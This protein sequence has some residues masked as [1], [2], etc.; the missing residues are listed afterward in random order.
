[1]GFWD[2][3]RSPDTVESLTAEVQGFLTTFS[4][5]HQKCADMRVIKEI[6]MD[7]EHEVNRQNLD[8]AKELYE[9]TVSSENARHASEHLVIE[10]HI[11]ALTR[12]IEI[13]S[14]ITSFFED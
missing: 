1:M 2:F 5:L 14:K 12:N 13:A 10:T 11:D 8:S 9:M 7:A 3:L 4:T 6:E